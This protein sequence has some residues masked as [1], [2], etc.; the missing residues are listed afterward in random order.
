MRDWHARVGSRQ[1]SCWTSKVAAT[2]D[3][4]E[5][6]ILPAALAPG[7]MPL[8][9][10][11]QAYYHQTASLGH[12]HEEPCLCALV[13]PLFAVCFHTGL[14]FSASIILSYQECLAGRLA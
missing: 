13:R 6:G 1:L 7:H 4:A 8:P 14:L 9:T 11:P 2:L 3:R 5:R 12:L 10:Q